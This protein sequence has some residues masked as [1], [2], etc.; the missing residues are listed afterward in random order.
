MGVRVYNSPLNAL[1][2]TDG[3]NADN[4]RSVSACATRSAETCAC[5]PS[6]Y[7]TSRR[8]M[9]LRA[10]LWRSNLQL[11]GWLSSISITRLSGESPPFFGGLLRS[12]AMTLEFALKRPIQHGWHQ[13]GQFPLRLSLPGPQRGHLRLQPIQVRHQP[14]LFRERGN[15]NFRFS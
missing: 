12:L 5:N 3:N 6:R 11:S 13:R 8:C 15:G 4:S 7:A 14:P 10:A 9:S 1:S 2:N